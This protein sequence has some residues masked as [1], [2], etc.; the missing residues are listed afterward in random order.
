MWDF[1]GVEKI[2]DQCGLEKQFLISHMKF[3]FTTLQ[4][5]L[6]LLLIPV[7]IWLLYTL[8]SVQIWMENHLQLKEFIL[9]I[10]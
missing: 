6:S 2:P 4:L 1:C 8:S 5:A 3:D 7:A 10:E 9:G